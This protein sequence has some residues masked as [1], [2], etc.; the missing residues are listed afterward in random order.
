MSVPDSLSGLVEARGVG[1]LSAKPA[2]RARL[3]AVLD[4]DREE[5]SRLPPERKIDMLGV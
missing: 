3:C 5:T 4:L 1:I 2:G